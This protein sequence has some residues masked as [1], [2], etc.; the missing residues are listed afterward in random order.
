MLFLFWNWIWRR[1]CDC[2]CTGMGYPSWKEKGNQDSPVEWYY[3]YWC[4][5]VVPLI[6]PSFHSK[7]ETA[8][9][10]SSVNCW[11]M[12]HACSF[13]LLLAGW[14]VLTNARKK[15][16]RLGVGRMMSVL[17]SEVYQQYG[18][19]TMKQGGLISL[20]SCNLCFYIEWNGM[21]KLKH[22]SSPLHNNWGTPP[23]CWGITMVA[24]LRTTSRYE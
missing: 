23:S 12:Y 24:L 14:G 8:V 1:V 20:C 15:L 6:Y 19:S 5:I 13:S 22:R 16:T 10:F 18:M 21:I 3:C 2:S 17:G 7:V 11:G 9:C 4:E